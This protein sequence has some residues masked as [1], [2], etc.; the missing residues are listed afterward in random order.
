MRC[1]FSTQVTP[2][3][4]GSGSRIPCFPVVCNAHHKMPHADSTADWELAKQV[5]TRLQESSAKCVFSYAAQNDQGACRPSTLVDDSVKEISSQALRMTIGV[6]T[7]GKE[8]EGAIQPEEQEEASV[9][10][11][12]V[13]LD[14][15]GAEILRMQAAC[16]FQAFAS[17]RLAARPMEETDWGLEARERGSVVHKILELLWAELKTRDALMAARDEGGGCTPWWSSTCAEPSGNSAPGL[18]SIAGA[19]PISMRRKNAS[20]R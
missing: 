11:W 13:E 19:R 15:G 17:R 8:D 20:C 3:G 7:Y 4:P 12:P 10:A 14:A 1:G 6:N 18:R 2:V 9:V 5:T 16:P